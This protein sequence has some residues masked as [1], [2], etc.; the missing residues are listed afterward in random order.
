MSLDSLLP[1]RI[2]KS[3]YFAREINN[4]GKL[5]SIKQ[6]I[7]LTE[8]E[9]FGIFAY[10]S[11]NCKTEAKKISFGVDTIVNLHFCASAAIFPL[12]CVLFN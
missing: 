2:R 5:L 4:I 1:A 7:Q 11:I 3:T 10:K 9:K 8:I 6:E 12:H